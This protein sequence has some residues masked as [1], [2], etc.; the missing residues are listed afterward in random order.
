MNAPDQTMQRLG[1][2]AK[3]AGDQTI[4]LLHGFGGHHADWADIQAELSRSARVIA[5][6]LPGHGRSLDVAGAGSAPAAGK[7]IL[8]D[9]AQRGVDAAHVVGFS[10]GGAIAVLMALR[11]PALI[12][13]LTLVAPGGFGPDINGDLLQRF[14]R[15]DGDGVRLCLNEMSGPGFQTLTRDA[16]G[17]AAMH[18]AK[19]QRE[20]LAEIAGMISRDNRQ[21]EIPRQQL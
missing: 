20:K 5:Y 18:G 8:A 13:S 17:A 19:G 14:A 2:T 3:G 9:L 10:M 12:R 11:A 1:A 21:G 15:A 6:D 16:A 7:A 4:V